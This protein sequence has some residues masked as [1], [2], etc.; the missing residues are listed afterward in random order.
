MMTKE[1]TGGIAEEMAEEGWLC[2]EA[3]FK[4]IASAQGISS[5]FIPKIATGFAAGIGRS[6]EVCGAVSGAIMGLGLKYGRNSLEETPQGKRP[7]EYAAALIQEIK[8][9]HGTAT[10][11]GVLGLNLMDPGDLETYNE[12]DHW[13]TT[14]RELIKEATALAWDL[15]QREP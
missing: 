3:V 12:L 15:L 11:A 14:C 10:C 5:Q 2:S 9:R 4:A 8:D 1:K 7:Y 6:E 13:N